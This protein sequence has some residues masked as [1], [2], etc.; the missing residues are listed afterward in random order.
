MIVVF[1]HQCAMSTACPATAPTW[2]S[3]GPGCRCSTA[4]R[5]T[6][7]CPATSMTTSGPTRCAATTAERSAPSSRPTRIRLPG[8]PSTPAGRTLVTT[9]P[10]QLQRPAGVGHRAGHRVPGARR[11]RH[12]RPDQHL[13]HRHGRPTCRRPRSS[14]S[15]TRSAGRRRPASPATRRTR[16]RT[17][18]GR[19][20]PTRATPT[21]TRSSTSTR[22]ERRGETTITFQYFAIPAVSDE[23]GTA[24]RR[25]HDA[26][27]DAVRDVR[28]RPRHLEARAAAQRDAGCHRDRVGARNQAGNGVTSPSATRQVRSLTAGNGGGGRAR[29]AERRHELREVVIAGGPLALRR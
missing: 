6:W 22:A 3:A 13:R 10:G 9:D 4:T 19:R 26:A 12:Q 21:A 2:A 11:R 24:A 27:D 25:H 20:P 17:R 1:M 7:C 5:S 18:P 29:R 28:L 8:K 14:P 15:A 16:S 23:T